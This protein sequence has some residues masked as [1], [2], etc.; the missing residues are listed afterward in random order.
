MTEHH[1]SRLGYCSEATHSIP[2][3]QGASRTDRP[4][5]LSPSQEWLSV[6]IVWQ[7]TVSAETAFVAQIKAELKAG[8]IACHRRDSG[9]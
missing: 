7:P 3:W 4:Q 5:A 1:S 8:R 9:V 6:L 2:A